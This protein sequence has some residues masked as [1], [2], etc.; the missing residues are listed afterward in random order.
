MF[1]TSTL[2]TKGQATIPQDLRLMFGF[3]PGDKLYFEGDRETKTIKV[4]KAKSKPS[5]DKL[6]GC[7]PSKM[8]YVDIKIT[9]EVAGQKLGEYY[10]QKLKRQSKS[11]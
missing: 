10:E 3:V 1:G 11:V 8:G 2:T 4:M 5:I 6:Y 7:L 9:R